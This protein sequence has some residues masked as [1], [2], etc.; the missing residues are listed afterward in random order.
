MFRHLKAHTYVPKECFS[1]IILLQLS[2]NFQRF[3]II[4]LC[5]DT[6][7]E[8]IGLW[9]LQKVPSV[10]KSLI[11]LLFIIPPFPISKV[12]SDLKKK[13]RLASLNTTGTTCGPH[14]ML[15][16]P[17]FESTKQRAAFIQEIT[18]NLKAHSEGNGAPLTS[19]LDLDWYYP[20]TLVTRKTQH[21]QFTPTFMSIISIKKARL[22]YYWVFS[23]RSPVMNAAYDQCAWWIQ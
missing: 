11:M 15:W 16:S 9:K 3:V 1:F 21:F 4:Y 18:Q 10:L 17:Q 22:I 23:Q 6:P 12:I 2:P 5:L 20:S 13:H 19:F 8:N 7:S 14:K